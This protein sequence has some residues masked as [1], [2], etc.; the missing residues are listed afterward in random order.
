MITT[1]AFR[2]LL[3]RKLR[4]LFLLAGFSLGVGVMIVLLS[5]GQAMLE[6]SH[7][8][9]AGLVFNGLYDDLQNW[10]SYGPYTAYGDGLGYRDGGGRAG[11]GG[12]DA[13]P[14][15]LPMAGAGLG[16]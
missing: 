6:Q 7:V 8:V 14:A 1:L 12:P 3:V 16:A 4:S 15:A 11:L 2:H 13:E 5:V 10:S 9:I